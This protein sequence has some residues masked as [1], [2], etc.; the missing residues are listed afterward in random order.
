MLLF[1]CWLAACG[2]EDERAG[3]PDSGVAPEAGTDADAGDCVGSGVSKGP[4]TLAI[5][6][7]AARIRW[8]AC[9]TGVSSR[10]TL[11]PE[12][13]GATTTLDAMVTETEVTGGF[14]PV[15]RPD[16]PADVPGTYWVH[17]ARAGGLEPGTCYRYELAA[18]P[19]A[20][21]RFCTARPDAEPFTFAAIGDTHPG[22]SDAAVLVMARVID[23]G[24]DFSL[25]TGDIQYY[26]G[27]LETWASWFLATKPWLRQGGFFPSIGNH[28]REE[29]NPS[30][31]EDFYLRLFGG[32]GFGGTDRYYRFRS[33]GVWFFALDTESEIGAGSTQA[34]WFATELASAAAQPGYRFGVVYF[35]KPF[36]T[37]GDTGQNDSARA[38]YQPLF[39]QHGV[40]LVL[41][42]HMHGYERFEMNGVTYVTTA[43]GGGRMGNVDENVS[44]PECA[45]R[46]AAG[47]WFHAM[48]FD[49]G[50]T[51]LR[52]SAIDENG[53][54][55]DGFEKPV[56]GGA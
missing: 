38:H 45:L 30:E 50:P 8:E 19:T 44:R 51:T 13:G 12:A 37:C 29:Q 16:F 53:Q 36:L 1:A 15:L 25:H 3:A 52:G 9:R 7:T 43:G 4:W 55:L 23:K 47:P 2:S 6:E 21:G 34:E 11:T 20:S 46:Q 24:F 48:S 35:H 17:D 5:E 32:A 56:P 49:V 27:A 33:G 42:G 31:L 10:L 40:S 26:S 28:E 14:V 39:E 54:V 22:F 41:Q 18:D